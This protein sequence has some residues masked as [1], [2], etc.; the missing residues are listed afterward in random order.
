MVSEADV[1]VAT[2]GQRDTGDLDD[3]PNCDRPSPD[4]TVD[5]GPYRR[6]GTFALR[7]WPV[8]SHSRR[9]NGGDQAL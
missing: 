3:R 2:D 8:A 7:V 6:S 9:L 4:R 5:A 1:R